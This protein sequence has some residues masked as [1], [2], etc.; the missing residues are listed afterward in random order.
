MVEHCFSFCFSFFLP[1]GLAGGSLSS[2]IGKGTTGPT[3]AEAG[4]EFAIFFYFLLPGF[5]AHPISLLL[6]TH[7]GLSLRTCHQCNNV[8]LLP[9]GSP[10]VNIAH[11]LLICTFEIKLN[12]RVKYRQIIIADKI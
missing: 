2:S 12:I 8:N 7:L 5:F 9:F 1:S 4:E 3:A 6:S 10:F 11:A